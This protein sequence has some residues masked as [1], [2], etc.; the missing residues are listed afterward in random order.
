M[1]K[2]DTDF[3]RWFELLQMNLAEKSINFKDSDSVRED[4]DDGKDLFDVVEEI[5]AEYVG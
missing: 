3:D 1:N 4:Y 5:A 2:Q